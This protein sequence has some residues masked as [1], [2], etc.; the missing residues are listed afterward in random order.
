MYVD[1]IFDDKSY[2]YQETDEEIQERAVRLNTLC[3]VYEQADRVLTGDPVIVNVVHEGDAPAWSD[4]QSITFN[5]SEIKD[6]DLESLTQINGLNYHE[7][8]HHLYTPR[9]G[10]TLLQWVIENGYNMSF[11][12]LEDQRIETLLIGRYP[13]IVPY[14]TATCARWLAETPEDSFTQYVAVR[15]RRYLPLNI[16]Q[17]F[18]E[19]F[20]FPELIPTI[21]EIIDEY[22]GLAF[23]RDYA[24]AQELIERFHNE[25]LRPMG[26]KDDWPA[27]PN[28][29]G[30]RAPISKGRPEPGKAQEKDAER[31]KKFGREESATPI[32]PKDAPLAEENA[33]APYQPKTPEEAVAIREHRVDQSNPGYSPTGHVKSVGG[34]PSSLADAL[35]NTIED[36]LIREDVQQDIR[37]KQRVIVGGDGKHMDSTKKGKF[38]STTVPTEAIASYRKFAQ[39]LM[40]LRDDL[41]P[42]WIREVPSG[43]FNVKRVMAG[44]E[45]DVAFDRWDEGS[46][47][48]DV[49]A[50][51]LV[52]RSGSMSSNRNDQKASIAC[53]TIKRALESINCAVTV[54]AFDDESEVAYKRDE[55]AH[56]TMYKFIFGDGGTHPYKSLLAA[57]QLFISSRKKNKMLFII[58]DGIFDARQNDEVIKRLSKRGVLTCAVLIMTQKE[59]DWHLQHNYIKD[60]KELQHGAEIFG[61]ISTAA[62]LVPFAKAVVT[63]AIR[64]RATR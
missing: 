4:G 36:V 55:Q 16:R 52:D 56:K 19:L 38:D 11:N 54:Y 32:K 13:A 64:K 33:P 18:R 22:R 8:A 6:M 5:L 63:G 60:E 1:P 25:V 48:A 53:W 40:R 57:E 62:D 50:V 3:R 23:P 26:L 58:T 39:E 21:S 42:T 61:R 29:C 15:G 30:P 20:A 34:L 2:Y 12:A 10:T 47:A 35:E 41:E 31:G 46:D 49:E 44:C 59:F 27:G 24:R 7:L 17:G 14:L 43:K 45:P 37:A 28:K 9:K 51:I